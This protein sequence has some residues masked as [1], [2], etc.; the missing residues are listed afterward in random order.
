MSDGL[1]AEFD[2]AHEGLAFGPSVLGMGLASIRG[3]KRVRVY[4]FGKDKAEAIEAAMLPDHDPD[5]PLSVL[6]GHKD[7]EL[8]LDAESASLL[9]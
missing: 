2:A 3:S 5:H 1:R 9:E 6:A 8:L 7:V 4:A